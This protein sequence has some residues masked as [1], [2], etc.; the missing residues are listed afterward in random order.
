[1]FSNTIYSMACSYFFSISLPST[2]C[3]A[4]CPTR[5]RAPFKG[6]CENRQIGNNS[7]NSS[8]L[9]CQYREAWLVLEVWD[10]CWVPAIARGR[11]ISQICLTSTQSLSVCSWATRSQGLH[12]QETCTRRGC[13]PYRTHRT[14]SSPAWASGWQK[15]WEESEEFRDVLIEKKKT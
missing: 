10:L 5:S 9:S 14:W 11:T 12:T 7:C 13:S 2:Y 4:G 6:K 1:M 15:S 3:R 8:E